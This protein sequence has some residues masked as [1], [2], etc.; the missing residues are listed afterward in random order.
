MVLINLV[1]TKY[2]DNIFIMLISL[3][4]VRKEFLKILNTLFHDLFLIFTTLLIFLI[5]TIKIFIFNILL[6][7]KFILPFKNLSF[8]YIEKNQMKVK[9]NERIDVYHILYA[10]LT[11]WV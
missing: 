7:L 5:L 9:I 2:L 11:F 1:M 8:L 4:L 10:R 3:L 6:I